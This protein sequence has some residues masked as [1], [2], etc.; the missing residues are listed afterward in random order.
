MIDRDKNTGQDKIRYASKMAGYNQA[1]KANKLNIQYFNAITSLK[2]VNFH[3]T[4]CIIHN[5]K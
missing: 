5:C 3:I 4:I 1:L 2:M